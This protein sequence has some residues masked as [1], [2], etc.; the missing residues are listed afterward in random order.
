MVLKKGCGLVVVAVASVVV[1]VVAAV[2]MVVV[3]IATAAV[4]EL[5]SSE[6]VEAINLHCDASIHNE[7]R[8]NY[9]NRCIL[10]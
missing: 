1:A 2:L 10:S 6:L 9:S 5:E 4:S 7:S 3:L 8:H